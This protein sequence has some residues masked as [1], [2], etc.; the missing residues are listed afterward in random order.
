MSIGMTVKE[1]WEDDPM[2]VRAY[3]KAH[4]LRNEKRN[5]E[6]WLQGL[7]NFAAFSTALSNMHFDGKK[8]KPN[9]YLKEPFDLTP[10]EEKDPEIEAKKAR[11]KLINQLNAWKEAW[12]KAHKGK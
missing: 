7:Y 10:P 3:Y 8:H 4:K 9:Q 5:Q 12:D 2:L 11:A 6:M 1:F